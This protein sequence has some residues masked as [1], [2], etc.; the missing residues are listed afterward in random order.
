VHDNDRNATEEI[1]HCAERAA[2]YDRE[3][4]FFSEDFEELR[5]AR[6]LL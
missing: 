4:R 2:I 6:Y 5:A 1:A 3:N